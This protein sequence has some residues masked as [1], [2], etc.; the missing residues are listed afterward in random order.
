MRVRSVAA[1]FG[2]VSAALGAPSGHPEPPRNYTSPQLKVSRGGNRS[3]DGPR[4]WL[5]NGTKS[6]QLDEKRTIV[7]QMCLIVLCVNPI[8]SDLLGH[9]WNLEPE[10]PIR[11]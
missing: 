3:R 4:S 9:E 8:V 7:G 11:T 10:V 5:N 2:C 1:Q 6:L